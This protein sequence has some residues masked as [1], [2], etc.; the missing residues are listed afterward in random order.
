LSALEI[1]SSFRESLWAVAKGTVKKLA[2]IGSGA[3][4]TN[5]PFL[6]APS[7]EKSEPSFG[8]EALARSV[9]NI[10]ESTVEITQPN[11]APA[12]QRSPGSEP[13][14]DAPRTV[15]KTLELS[16]ADLIENATGD[17]RER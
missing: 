10:E 5:E 3:A 1:K 7:N 11:L 2:G 4:A 17:T 6:G 16:D 8:R 15:E 9:M 12:T 14:S 13:P